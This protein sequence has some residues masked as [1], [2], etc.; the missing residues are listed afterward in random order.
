MDN[1]VVA[2]A[3]LLVIGLII[4]ALTRK[5]KDPEPYERKEPPSGGQ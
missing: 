4:F 1:L 5:P 2:G 3:V